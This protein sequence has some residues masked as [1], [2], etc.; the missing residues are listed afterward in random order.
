MLH[1]D[2][3]VEVFLEIRR[4]FS[5]VAVDSIDKATIVLKA[6]VTWLLYR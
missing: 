4:Q 2:V 3:G 6:A 5:K 1:Q